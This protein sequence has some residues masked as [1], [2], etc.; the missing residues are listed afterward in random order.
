MIYTFYCPITQEIFTTD[1]CEEL[2]E[3][4]EKETT[5]SKKSEQN[6]GEKK[7]VMC[8]AKTFSLSLPE[9]LDHWRV[10]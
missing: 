1:L 2:S 10:W 6:K 7:K 4:S 8:I 5:L 9:A 3:L